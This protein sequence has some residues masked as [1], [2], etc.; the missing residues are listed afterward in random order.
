MNDIG[1]SDLAPKTSKAMKNNFLGILF[2]V[3][4]LSAIAQPGERGGKFNPELRRAL[5]E[6]F[7][8]QML[9]VLSEQNRILEAGLSAS[10]LQFLEAKRDQ[11]T[12]LKEQRRALHRQAREQMRQGKSPEEI[13]ALHQSQRQALHES[14][15][16]LFDELKPLVARNQSLID[17]IAAALQPHFQTWREQRRALHEQYRPQDAPPRPE[18]KREGP[19]EHPRHG[20]KEHRQHQAIARFLLWDMPDEADD[21]DD[22]KPVPAFRTSE[23]VLRLFPNPAGNQVTLQIDLPAAVKQ[24]SIEVLDASGRSLR[25]QNLGALTAGTHNQAVALDNLP[26]GNYTLRLNLD[27][28]PLSKPLLVKQ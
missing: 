17:G 13:K 23:A 5:R 19:G 28:K 8:T 2:C 21:D 11:W 7:Q 15:R 24:A 14:Q 3:M 9:P 16:A 22:D 26:A 18:P 20:V 12:A 25:Q 6:H 10:D 1:I 4:T 27:G